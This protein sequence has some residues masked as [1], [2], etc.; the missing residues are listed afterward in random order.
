M[1]KV[2]N[3]FFEFG[4]KCQ[5]SRQRPYTVRTG[6]E[7]VHGLPGS[8]I[9]ARVVDQTQITVGGIHSHLAPAYPDT[10]AGEYLLNRLV[11]E[12]KVVLLYMGNT[13]RDGP[14]AADHCIV[15]F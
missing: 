15:C 12:I 1:L 7:F 8:F 5:S 2:R 4:V 3:G 9:D 14:D 6:A 11:V 13:V 10:H